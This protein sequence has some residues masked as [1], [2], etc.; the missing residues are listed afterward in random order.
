MGGR[1]GGGRRRVAVGGGGWEGC[2][3]CGALTSGP[4]VEVYVSDHRRLLDPLAHDALGPAATLRRLHR[5]SAGRATRQPLAHRHGKGR[6]RRG[7][8]WK[9]KPRRCASR[10]QGAGS[11]EVKQARGAVVVCWCRLMMRL[12]RR[13]GAGRRSSRPSVRAFCL[14]QP[15]QPDT[16]MGSAAADSTQQAPV[17]STPVCVHTT[18][19]PHTPHAHYDVRCSSAAP[20]LSPVAPGGAECVDVQRL[21]SVVLAAAH[22]SLAHLLEHTRRSPPPGLSSSPCLPAPLAASSDTLAEQ[23]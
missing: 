12:R 16:R 22:A 23:A 21:F 17:S 10:E 14:P 1:R 15:T 20:H 9:G 2:G 8:G 6:Q 4:F 5:R 13:G 11:R 18:R 3:G 19:T 7:S